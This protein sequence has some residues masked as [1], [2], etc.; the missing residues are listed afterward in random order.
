MAPRPPDPVLAVIAALDGLLICPNG[1]YA[2]AGVFRCG[3]VGLRY[4]PG[5]DTTVIV[6]PSAA[7]EL[8]LYPESEAAE[9]FAQYVQDELMAAA[10]F[11]QYVYC[12][13]EPDPVNE[14]GS[15]P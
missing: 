5:L 13:C 2:V 3:A 6:H 8:A 11:D 4:D 10:P 14:L 15:A 1:M 7:C 9:D 12:Y